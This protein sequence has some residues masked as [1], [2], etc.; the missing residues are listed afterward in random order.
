MNSKPVTAAITLLA[1]GLQAQEPASRFDASTTLNSG[2]SA[3]QVPLER[4][5]PPLKLGRSDYTVSG[6]LVDT[7]L[8]RRRA[9]PDRSLGRKILDLPIINMFVP[10]PM[11]KPTRQGKYF[12]WGETD[13]PWSVRADRP[14]PG[15]QGVLV[16]V[17][18]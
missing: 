5:T 17:S 4:R 14:I 13:V 8:T 1:F 10:A 18:R 6:P 9:S 15:P 2:S 11:P 7:F 12:A 3:W 16:S